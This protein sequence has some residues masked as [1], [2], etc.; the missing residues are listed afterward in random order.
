MTSLSMQK[1]TKSQE[2]KPKSSWNYIISWFLIVAGY[3]V[4]MHKWIAFYTKSKQEF[5]IK[6][7]VPFILA[8]KWKKPEWLG[9]NWQNMYKLYM[10]KAP[11]LKKRQ[12]RLSEEV[13]ST[14]FVLTWFGIRYNPNQSSSK[15]FFQKF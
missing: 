5:E 10:K 7:P 11:K 9:I 13:P 1:I 2:I 12:R 8:P 3:K 4:N 6:T 15:L 14:C